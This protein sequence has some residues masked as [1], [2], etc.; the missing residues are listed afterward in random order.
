VWTPITD[1]FGQEAAAG[2]AGAPA[3]TAS[4]EAEAT[5][6]PA[7]GGGEAPGG[8]KIGVVSFLSGAAAAPFGVPSRN[9]AELLIEQ[10]N[11]GGAPAPYEQVGI[12]GVPIRTVYIDEAGGA[13]QQVAEYRRLVLDEQVDLVI[14]Y[15]SSAD[16][17]AVAPVAEELRTLTV[18]FDCG[19]HQIFEESEHHYLFRTAGHQII[20][21]V[22]AAR[23]V[24]QQRPELESIA[25]INQNY[26]W[27]QDSWNTFRDS[28]LQLKPDVSVA[29]EQFP[30]LGAGEYSAEISSLLAAGPDVVHSSFWGGDLEG[31]LIQSTPRGLSQQ[32]LLVLTTGDT[33]LPRLGANV[34]P[35]IIIGAR[36][37][38]G[39]LA[40][41]SDLNDW[42][43][44]SYRNRYGARPVYPSYHMSQAILGVKAAYER[45]MEANGGQW[46]DV[47]Q[48][49][50]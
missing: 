26:A 10:L 23:Y 16:C 22:G 36:G 43:V 33:V 42:F 50:A 40:P 49:I 13:D 28:V 6:A 35:G 18:M 7:T 46:P 45:A 12:G 32:S 5:S 30:Q 3:A 14:G 15:I 48:V 24:L 38:H 21:N 47:E 11:A 20:D 8:L 31:L 37:P 41:A 2:A 34:P 44:E 9:A 1:F 27:G 29:A 19:T 25:G 39:A 17:L 4:P